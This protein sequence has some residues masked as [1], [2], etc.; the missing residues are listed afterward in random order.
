MACYLLRQFWK[1]K[2]PS[3]VRVYDPDTGI[4][5]DAIFEEEITP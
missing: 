2:Q 1:G 3:L 4:Q 5:R